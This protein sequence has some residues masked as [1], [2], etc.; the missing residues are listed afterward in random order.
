MY[1]LYILPNHSFWFVAGKFRVIWIIGHSYIFWS[2]QRAKKRVYIENLGLN[3]NKFRVFWSGTRILLSL[4]HTVIVFSEMV[5]RLRWLYSPPMRP[6]E[7][8]WKQENRAV[9][10]FLLSLGILSFRLVELEGL[11]IKGL[12]R[13]DRNLF[14]WNWNGCF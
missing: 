6:L 11:Y 14:I 1:L 12:Y 8:N 3:P 5:Q 10:T 13:K 4:R 7:K 2:Q 9:A